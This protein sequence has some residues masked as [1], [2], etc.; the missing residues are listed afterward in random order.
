MA[1]VGD[2][3]AVLAGVGVILV[4]VAFLISMVRFVSSDLSQTVSILSTGFTK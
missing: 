2:L 3:T 4:L 1:G